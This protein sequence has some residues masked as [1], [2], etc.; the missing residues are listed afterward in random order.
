MAVPP[1]RLANGGADLF[2]GRHVASLLFASTVR[3]NVG[4]SLSPRPER[5]MSTF[6]PGFG[7]RPALRA[8]ECMRRL[9]GR[10][11]ALGAAALGERLERF[12]IGGG[13]VAHAPGPQQQRMLGPDARIVE[14][15]GHRIRFLDLAVVVLQQQRIRALQHAGPA[16]G[17]RRGVVAELLARAAR[18]DADDL[19]RRVADER[20]EHADR[21]RAAAHAG[22]HRV[23]QR[24]R[25]RSSICARASLADHGLQLAHE[26]RIRMRADR[27]TDDVES[28]VGIARPSRGTPRRWRRAA[29]GRRWSPAP[30]WRLTTSCGRRSAPGAP[31]RPRPCTP[32]TAARRARRPRRSRRHAGR[33]RSPRRCACAPSRFA[34][35]AWPSAL[36]ILCA[37]VCA[38]SSRLSHTSAPQAFDSF[39]A[40]VSAV[41]RPDP[42]RELAREL[43][44]EVR[45]VQVLLHA[46]FEVLERGEQRLGDVAAA[47]RAEAAARVGKFSGELVGQ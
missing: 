28:V 26:V 23:G 8:R 30:P 7:S 41:G 39:G 33:R 34:S 31:C 46:G 25:L 42:A 36:L 5:P 47:E 3:C 40:C 45:R 21:I 37:P 29:S 9:D 14:A 10:Q 27:R 15:R 6:L 11:D 17:E 18:F 43:R 44:L 13:F 35:S 19:H 22:D 24:A 16:V 4:M 20:M 12:V 32:C 38:R 1:R 2:A